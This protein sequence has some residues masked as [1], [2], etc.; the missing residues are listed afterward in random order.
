MLKGIK[1]YL[2]KKGYLRLDTLYKKTM[3]LAEYKN[4]IN[5]YSPSYRNSMLDFIE[6]D[7]VIYNRQLDNIIRQG[8]ETRFVTVKDISQN[9]YT[10][11]SFS[12]W[13]SDNG[14]VIENNKEIDRFI[15]QITV[16]VKWYEESIKNMTDATLLNNTRRLKPY[17][18]NIETIVNSI[19]KFEELILR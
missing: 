3:Y 17:Y 2:Y 11:T 13:Y 5:F 4:N 8:L 7:I 9:S 12:F 19:L 14:K 1:K 15:H 6:K 16:F 18:N 10:Y